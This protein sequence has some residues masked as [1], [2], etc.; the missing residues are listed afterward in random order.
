MIDERA[1]STLSGVSDLYIVDFGGGE[2]ERACREAERGAERRRL[3]D[4]YASHL[5]TSAGLGEATAPPDTPKDR[6]SRR[7]S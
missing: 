2:Q 3:A 4:R 5:V 1:V 7:G 6:R